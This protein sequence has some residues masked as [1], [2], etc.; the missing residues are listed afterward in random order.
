[1]T[2]YRLRALLALA[3]VKRWPIRYQLLSLVL[4]VA[5]PFAVLVSMNLYANVRQSEK[6]AH[7]TVRNVAQDLKLDTE[8]FLADSKRRLEFLAARPRV[9]AMDPNRCDPLLFEIRWLLPEYA[10]VALRD[11]DGKLVCG[12]LSQPGQWP[13]STA[14]IEWFREGKERAEFTVGNALFGKVTRKWVS[15]LTY[16]VRDDQRQLRGLLVL[17][18]DLEYF[19]RHA[20]MFVLPPRSIIALIDRDGTFIMHSA[21]PGRVGQNFRGKEITDVVLRGDHGEVKAVG[22]DTIERIYSYNTL[23][24]AGWHVYA[25]IPSDIVMAPALAGAIEGATITAALLAIIAGLGFLISRGIEAPLRAI[26]GVASEIARG[27]IDARATLDGSREIAQIAAQFNAMLD[28]QRIAQQQLRG[29]EAL[30]NETQALSK[31]GGWEYD[32][33]SDSVKWTDE[34]YRIFEVSRDYDPS[35]RQQNIQSY[36]AGERVRLAEAFQRAVEQGEPYDLELQFVTAGGRKRWV[37]TVGQAARKEGKIVRVFGN[38]IDITKRKR[39]ERE[40]QHK[41]ELAQLLE[42]LARAANEAVSP[43]AAM[44]TCL[45]RICEHGRWALGHV[46]TFEPGNP[47]FRPERSLWF[48]Q[49]PAR[50]DT[51]MRFCDGYEFALASSSFIGVLLGEHRPVWVADLT[52]IDKVKSGR[53]AKAVEAGLTAAFAFPV[54]VKG[55]IVAILEFFAN[56]SRPPDALLMEGAGGLASQF[57]RM[58]ERNAADEARAR[59]AA[60]VEGL[61]DAIIGRAIDGP[62]TSWNAAAERILGYTAAEVIG[63]RLME[64]HP[65]ELR[66]EFAERRKRMLAGY[67][68]ASF[69]S[70]RITKDGR[71]IDVAV[72]GSA[73]KDSSGNIIGTATILR[74]IAERKR[75]EQELQDYAMRLQGLSRRLVDIEETERRKINRELHDRVGQNLAALDIQLNI[76]RSRLSQESL[77]DVSAHLEKSQTLLAETAAH[78]R[79][80]MADLRPPAL[81]EYGLLASLCS[82]VDSVGAHVVIPITVRGEDLAP[83]L[84]PAAEMALFRIAQGAITNAIQH[85]HAKR[86]EVV[87][88]ATPEWVTLTIADDGAGFDPEYVLPACPS[89]GLTIMRERAEAVGAQLTMESTP[90][91]GTRVRVEID[92]VTG[93]R[94]AMNADE[95]E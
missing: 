5:V 46:I 39:A 93:S 88:V 48:C 78:A 65:P 31:V 84:S 16:P 53:L 15:V 23:P 13:V 86:I 6:S 52:V 44:E 94:P 70:V 51:F 42:Q 87:L 45:A 67:Q 14:D 60:I 77:R 59:L 20:E 29:S 11:I 82:Y 74:D 68:V 72:S 54:I 18:I 3:A 30:L 47:R 38:I 63:R 34:L 49:E 95:H 50:F 64:I 61:N 66:Q 26:G 83:R 91:N 71:R 36:P 32:V 35:N 55:K 17:P 76:I 81:D 57:A 21:D 7:L 1:M 22:T 12:D 80:V 2:S 75:V 85:A 37:R 41:T 43:E 79:N 24:G 33:A 19:Q 25:G 62:V 40:L 9:K 56:E 27:N 90:G 8:M 58:I 4:V 69:E 89:W 10:N 28:A 73:V 92:R